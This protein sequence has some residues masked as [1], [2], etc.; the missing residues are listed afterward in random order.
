MKKLLY[1]IPPV[2]VLCLFLMGLV[3]QGNWESAPS[4]L[5]SHGLQVLSVKTDV[6]ASAP[7][8]NGVTFSPDVFLRGLNRRTIDSITVKT[9]P[10]P[11]DGCLSMGS[12]AVAA[13][14]TI[15]A[16]DLSHLVFEAAGEGEVSSSFLFTVDSDPLQLVCRVYLTDTQNHAPTLS[17]VPVLSL[18][19]VTYQNKQTVGCL[20]SYDPD[21]DAPIYEVVRYPENGGLTLHANT[22]AYTYTPEQNFT[23]EDAFVYV[24]RDR[25]GNYSASATVHLTVQMCGTSV[26]YA[27][28]EDSTAHNAAL[29]LLEAGIMN[30]RQLGTLHYFYPQETVSRLDFLVMAMHAAGIADLPDCQDTGFADDKEIPEDLKGYVATAYAMK[31]IS[32]TV[33]EGKLCFLPQESITRAEAA[34]ILS[35]IVGI[36]DVAVTPTFSDGNDIPAWA[37]E[38]VYSLHAIGILT[39]TDG[40][41]SPMEPLTREQTALILD[42]AKRYLE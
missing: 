25:Y 11:A 18:E 15:D 21:G 1:F 29:S 7:I 36:E 12:T 37:R 31:Y 9:L 32:G 28:M 22:G 39:A 20:S 10:S 34:L 27:D 42:A 8:G 14:Q 38:S 35:A 5:L 26:V 3:L 17:T 41:I 30:G 2:L 23:G 16:R 19:N 24:A 6:G 4:A 40:A 13:G 33:R